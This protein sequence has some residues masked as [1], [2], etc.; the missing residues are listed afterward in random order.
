M[1]SATH[2]AKIKA[3]AYKC[4]VYSIVLFLLAIAQVTF[5][6][7]INVL[8]SPPDLI[9]GA[10][11]LLCLK[12]EHK[13]TAICSIVSGILYCSL[14]GVEYPVYI[15]FSFLC[16]YILWIVAERSFGKN[17][18]SYLALA[19]LGFGL[20]AL[21]NVAYSSMFSNNFAILGTILGIVIPEF[22][23]SMIFC[24]LPYLIFS[25]LFKLLNKKSRKEPTQK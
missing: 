18:P 10:I 8:S 21:F 13:V 1:I 2:Y 25:F 14:G 15:I 23:S 22:I 17:Y 11:L 7:K 5:F 3:I 12:E 16:G 24:S 20:K 6:S 4:T 19:A 9:L